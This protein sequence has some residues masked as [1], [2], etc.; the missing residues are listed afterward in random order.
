MKKLI[1]YDHMGNKVAVHDVFVEGSDFQWEATTPTAVW[2]GKI[3]LVDKEPEAELEQRERLLDVIAEQ[4][5]VTEVEIEPETPLAPMTTGITI[6][7]EKEVESELETVGNTSDRD[8]RSNPP[9]EPESVEKLPE[10]TAG[11]KATKRS[12]G[13]RNRKAA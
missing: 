5:L 9:G 13:V 10:D 1:L 7:E 3:I 6:L 12:R 8:T 4:P 2:F 11:G